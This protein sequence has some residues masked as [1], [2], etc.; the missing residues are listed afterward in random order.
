MSTFLNYSTS[1]YGL[2]HTRLKMSLTSCLKNIL[3][4]DISELDCLAELWIFFYW[5][6]YCKFI[7]GHLVKTWNTL[8]ALNS[9]VPW[10]WFKLVVENSV[11]D[12]SLLN[13]NFQLLGCSVV[14]D[15]WGIQRQW[16]S[17]IPGVTRAA[18]WLL[19][20]LSFYF[21]YA[22][23]IFSICAMMGKILGNV[24]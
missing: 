3:T 14:A 22:V 6:Y 7:V 11:S 4:S 1:F 19:A 12:W 17:L 23:Q 24:A 10:C 9:K 18:S 2:S 21:G 20:A 5:E 16:S 8:K 13:Q 15:S